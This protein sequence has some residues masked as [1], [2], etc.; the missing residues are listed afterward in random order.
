[1]LRTALIVYWSATGNTEKVAGAI[2]DGFRETDLAV[3]VLETKGFEKLDYFEYDLVCVGFPVHRFHPPEIMDQ[4]LKNR[5]REDQRKQRILPGSPVVEGKYALIF[6]TYSGPHSG[7]DEAVPAVKY[8]GQFFA[9]VG[10]PV[11][12]EWYV[13]GEFHGR[14]DLSTQGKLGDIRGK[15]TDED[16]DKVRKDAQRLATTLTAS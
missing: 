16:L 3:T 4:F 2:S 8:A 12:D 14:E 11:I 6:C 5:F 1:M 10:I 13:V 7:I 9:H 15:P